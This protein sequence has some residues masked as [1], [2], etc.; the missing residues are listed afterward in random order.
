MSF[1]VLKSQAPSWTRMEKK[2]VDKLTRSYPDIDKM[3][4]KLLVS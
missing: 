1:V 4:C 2:L 3:P